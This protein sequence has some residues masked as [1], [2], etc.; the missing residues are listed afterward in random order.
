MAY[1]ILIPLLKLRLT[2]RCGGLSVE[3]VRDGGAVYHFAA[4]SRT[5]NYDYKPPQGGL[6][7]DIAALC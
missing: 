1:H 2:H 3:V 4:I 7:M 6:L 5:F